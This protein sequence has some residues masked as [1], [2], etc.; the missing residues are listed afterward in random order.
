DK[1]TNQV[2]QLPESTRAVDGTMVYQTLLMIR[3]EMDDSKNNNHLEDEL[4]QLKS[5]VEQRKKHMKIISEG[6]NYFSIGYRHLFSSNLFAQME[7]NHY[8]L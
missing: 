3:F 5:G 2:T 1:S 4:A 8:K 7:C 6:M